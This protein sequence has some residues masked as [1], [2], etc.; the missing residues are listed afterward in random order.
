M[1]KTDPIQDAG[2]VTMDSLRQMQNRFAGELS[3]PQALRDI[4][5]VVK[6]RLNLDSKPPWNLRINNDRM[7]GTHLSLSFL[8]AALSWLITACDRAASRDTFVPNTL[9]LLHDAGFLPLVQAF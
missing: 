9:I 2:S 1:L 8:L 6:G 7:Y 5:N 4:T 3:L